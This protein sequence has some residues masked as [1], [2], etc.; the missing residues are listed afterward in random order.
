VQT[1]RRSIGCFW[2]WGQTPASVSRR[3]FRLVDTS[4]DAGGNFIDTISESFDAWVPHG[5][6][7]NLVLSCQCA[8][9]ALHYPNGHT[10]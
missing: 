3:C 2:W 5:P 1:S 6:E 8:P 4:F 7:G 10:S 9:R